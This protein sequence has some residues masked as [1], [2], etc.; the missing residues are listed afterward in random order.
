[1]TDENLESNPAEAKKR[2][3]PFFRFLFLINL[4]AL[5]GFVLI[6]SKN[7]YHYLTMSEPERISFL[8]QRDFELLEIS[9]VLPPEIQDL[10]SIDLIGTSQLS[11]SWIQ[12]IKIPIEKKSN[13]HHKMEILVMGLEEPEF[14]GA[15]IQMNISEIKSNNH[16][17]E[18]GRTYSL[19]IAPWEQKLIET[20]GTGPL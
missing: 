5:L 3:R 19:K 14:R 15:V 13:G 12:N 1:M 4:L 7:Y 10:K 6:T 17:W 16:V 20:L 9:G 8:W 18:L 11:K 2:T